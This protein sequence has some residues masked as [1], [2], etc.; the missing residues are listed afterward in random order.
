MA[1][2]RTTR[3]KTASTTTPDRWEL[4]HLVKDPVN[5]LETH[6]SSL[7]RQVA[8]SES[9]RPRTPLVRVL[10]GIAAVGPD[11]EDERTGRR[12]VG[13]L[14]LRFNAARYESTGGP[15]GVFSHKDGTPY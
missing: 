3:R 13:V 9:S 1:G 7:D 11:G 8:Q 15:G 6:L 10:E 12:P 4:T 2:T 14:H 5:L